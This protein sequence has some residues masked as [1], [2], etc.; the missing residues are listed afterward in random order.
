[1][2]KL[3]LSLF[4]AGSLLSCRNDDVADGD[5]A[6]PTTDY[7]VFGTYY[8]DCYRNCVNL[9]LINNDGLYQVNNHD[10]PY[11]QHRF[12][13][14][15]LTKLSDDKYK[16]VKNLWTEFPSQLTNESKTVFGCPDC[17]DGGGTYLETSVDGEIKYWYVDNSGVNVPSYINDYAKVVRESMSSL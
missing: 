2:K 10:Y 5:M 13:F 17:A 15:S 7:L 4:I 12:D 9:Y 14:S 6:T 3:I 1:M 8:G 11:F 16:I